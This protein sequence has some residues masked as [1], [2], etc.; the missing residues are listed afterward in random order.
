MREL[1]RGL[2]SEFRGQPVARVSKALDVKTLQAL[3]PMEKIY[4]R[5]DGGGLVI[6]VRPIGAKLSICR[7]TVDGKRCDMG[8]ERL[9]ARPRRGA[10]RL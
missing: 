5:S 3:K 4:R 9:E 10:M 8:V 6:E 1:K 7:L 2:S